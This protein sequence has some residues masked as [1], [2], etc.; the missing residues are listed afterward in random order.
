MR[1]ISLD[2]DDL[3]SVRTINAHHVFHQLP[4]GALAWLA[5]DE[6]SW[7]DPD[8]GESIVVAGDDL[9]EV[10]PDGTTRTV[11]STW[12]DLPVVKNDGWDDGFYPG[13]QDWTHA[14]AIFYDAT[15]DHY[16]V[17]L[18]DADSVVEIERSTGKM[19]RAFGAYGWPAWK[20]EGFHHPHDPNWSS[21]GTLMLVSTDPTTGLTTGNEYKVDAATEQL[22]LLGK[23]GAD[24]NVHGFGLGQFRRL[25]NGNLLL[26]FGS[27]GTVAELTPDDVVVWRMDISAGGWLGQVALIDDLYAGK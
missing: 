20:D 2:G 22:V 26:N 1:R 10:A 16:L 19:L 15:T 27:G 13:A 11:W 4:D 9:D 18:G 3:G 23:H 6:R 5:V 7:V 21:D 8:T 24:L 25:A 12:N 14:N 17:G